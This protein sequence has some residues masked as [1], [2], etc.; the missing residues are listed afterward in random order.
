M[1]LLAASRQAAAVGVQLP[2]KRA[3]VYTTAESTSPR[4][5]PSV[6]F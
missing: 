6:V 2:G 4:L 5:T 1:L 3:I